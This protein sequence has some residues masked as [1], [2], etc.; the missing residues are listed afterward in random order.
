MDHSWFLNIWVDHEDYLTVMQEAWESHQ[1]GNPLHVLH[2]N[3]KLVCGTLSCWSRTAFGD[4]YE[5]P[6]RLESLIKTLEQ[7]FINNNTPKNRMELSRAKAEYTR[8]LKIQE[9]V[10]SKKAR[11]KSLEEGD[12]NSA[13]FHSVIKDK[14]KRLSIQKIKD[15]DGNWV[16]G[17][18][19]VVNAT[20]NFSLNSLKLK[21]LKKTV[22]S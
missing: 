5:E 16:E 19:Q 6:K 18:T 15:Q 11:V 21:L 4:F 13:F 2:Q 22:Q 8:F 1:E 12:T 7:D 17:T 3:L 20:V 14:R 9:K 10:L